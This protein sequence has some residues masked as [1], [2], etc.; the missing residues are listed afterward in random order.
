MHGRPVEVPAR[1]PLDAQLRAS[2]EDAIAQMFKS[3]V[4]SFGD[5]SLSRY[6]GKP[7]SEHSWT[8]ACMRT[9]ALAMAGVDYKLW[10]K[11]PKSGEA[12]EVTDHPLLGLLNN[13][14]PRLYASG[15]SFRYQLA[16]YWLAGGNAWMIPDQLELSTKV[17]ASLVVLGRAH[18]SP[19]RVRGS[20][21]MLSGWDVN[22]GGNRKTVPPEDLI[23]IKFPVDPESADMVMGVAPLGAA[24]NAIDTDFAAQ[25]WNNAFFRNGAQAGVVLQYAPTKSGANE[26]LTDEQRAQIY[27][28]WQED[29]KGADRAH[30][31][32]VLHGPFKIEKLGLSQKDMDFLD[33]RR[34]SREEIA[35][36]LGVSAVLV[37]ATENAGLS[38]AGLQLHRRL[39]YEN[40]VLPMLTILEAVWQRTLV[41]VWAPGLVGQFAT[42]EI[43]ALREDEERTARIAVAYNSIGVPLNDLIEKLDLPFEK[44]PYGDTVY[45]PVNQA[46]AEAIAGGGVLPREALPIP[47]AKS[48]GFLPSLERLSEDME[49][50]DLPEDALEGRSSRVLPA[51]ALPAPTVR[52]SNGATRSGVRP[53]T[54]FRDAE[55]REQR[56]AFWREFVSTFAP[57][58]R[59]Y[60]RRVRSLFWSLRREVLANLEE[61]FADREPETLPAAEAAG[62]EAAFLRTVEDDI[63]RILFNESD[64]IR[65][66]RELSAPYFKRAI[67][68]GTSGAAAEL[69]VEAIG[70]SNESAQA[71]LAF[72]NIEVKRIPVTIREQLRVTLGEG[73]AEGEALTDI[74]GRVR[75]T[76]A[77]S[78]ARARTIARTEIASA[79]NGGRFLEHR[80]QGVEK[81]EW[82]SA[83]D[84]NVRTGPPYNHLIDEEVVVIGQPFSNGLVF[85]NDPAGD[86]GNIISCRCTTVAIVPDVKK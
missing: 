39:L 33:S 20:A 18:V 74:A 34:L 43:Q 40:T 73:L 25:V 86:P 47:G 10:Q 6:R 69:G 45:L 80:A 44:Q 77:S 48:A 56:A 72:K 7:Y 68:T 24:Q 61:V 22:L 66:L 31:L 15:H 82:L 54:A 41:D 38:Q 79:V 19:K 35:A 65:R 57:L 52:E 81:H 13:P 28:G 46:P 4:E 58:E 8:Y 17:P 71:F 67:E 84:D 51:L 21:S 70:L 55:K 85:P 16:L 83:Q 36:V 78:S 63:R 75:R 62:L 9:V 53:A 27:E 64:A 5:T 59:S 30:G 3:G 60:R 26:W 76:F 12:T 14:E 23:H 2:A 11:D 29:H 32:A 37:N 42:D 50:E 49:E 1:A